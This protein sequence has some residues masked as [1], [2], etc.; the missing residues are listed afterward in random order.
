MQSKP[1]IR[2]VQWGIMGEPDLV[3]AEAPAN[4]R[5]FDWSSLTRQSWWHVTEGG[6]P[7]DRNPWTHLGTRKSAKDRGS[8]L[9]GQP[10]SKPQTMYE[11]QI[12]SSL[13]FAPYVFVE[14]KSSGR[15]ADKLARQM[16]YDGRYNAAYY[17]NVHEDEGSIS[18]MVDPVALGRLEQPDNPNV[19]WTEQWP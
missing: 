5:G 7:I 4:L 9:A 11:V 1:E 8:I 10:W 3:P 14:G 18:L 15:G 16:Q 6:S 17:I 13:R 12:S 2:Y 19:V